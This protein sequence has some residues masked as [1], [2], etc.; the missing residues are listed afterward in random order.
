KASLILPSVYPLGYCTDYTPR[1]ILIKVQ[2]NKQDGNMCR[3]VQCKVCSKTTWAGCGNHIAEVKASVPK[4]QWCP[5]NHSQTEI[6]NAQT[7]QPGFLSR[8]FSRSSCASI[9][10]E[11]ICMLLEHI[12]DTDLAQGSYFIGCQENNSAIVVDPR[13]DVQVYLDMAEQHGMDIV[14]VVE[15]H[16]HADYLSGT[17]ELANATGAQVYVSD[18]GGPDW[19]YGSGFD[20]AS[21]IKH[22]HQIV[23]GNITVEAVHTPG[24]TPE[25]LSFLIPDG[26]QST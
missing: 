23:L 22:G 19:T 6:D 14:A 9:C 5:G 11:R 16:I 3:P 20:A 25:H 17:L 13:R 4:D 2:S 15:T 1:G 24:H 10:S 18:E 7:S 21:R 12:Y 8:L 26:A